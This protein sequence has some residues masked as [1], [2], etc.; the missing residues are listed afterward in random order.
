MMAD[1]LSLTLCKI[2]L[3]QIGSRTGILT[4]GVTGGFPI[5]RKCVQAFMNE[6]PTHPLIATMK[7]SARRHCLQGQVE[8]VGEKQPATRP[9]ENDSR[10]NK[11]RHCIVPISIATRCRTLSL[12][13]GWNFSISPLRSTS[14]NCTYY[15]I[16]RVRPVFAMLIHTVYLISSHDLSILCQSQIALALG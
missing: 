14:Q 16:V 2:G 11:I 10:S 3:T 8:S 13:S 6:D 5:W 1:F 4:T 9:R 12:P 15:Q 7:E